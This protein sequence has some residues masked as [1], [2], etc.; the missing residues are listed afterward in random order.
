MTNTTLKTRML[1]PVWDPDAA[2]SVVTASGPVRLN[3]R[4][5]GALAAANW[6]R[7]LLM[8]SGLPVL[9]PLDSVTTRALRAWPSAERPWSRTDTTPGRPAVACST[10]S[11][12]ASSDESSLPP[13]RLAIISAVVPTFDVWNGAA[14]AAAC[15]LGA[16][17][18]KNTALLD[19]LTVDRLGRNRLAAI[20]PMI[21]TAT[22][23]HR[24]RTSNRARAASVAAA[25]QPPPAVGRNGVGKGSIAM[26]RAAPR[27]RLPATS[28]RRV[29]APAR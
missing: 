11:I 18:G 26:A 19:W 22:I 13:D 6:A 17:A 28:E 21:Q 5:G 7:M 12:A 20:A 16:P 29:N 27:T 1:V 2:A 24:N 25:P 23:S 4:P 8:R 15:W 14:S 10:R 9:P 3:V